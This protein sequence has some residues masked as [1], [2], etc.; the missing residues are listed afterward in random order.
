MPPVSKI[1][2]RAMFAAASGKSNI[3][4][5]SKVGKEFAKTMHGK[6]MSD[7]PKQAPKPKK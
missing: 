2:A 7:L 6:K 1:Q 4:I 3:G 5:T